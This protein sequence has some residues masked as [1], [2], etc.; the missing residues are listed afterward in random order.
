MFED[1][2]ELQDHE[3]LRKIG[4][5]FQQ[6]I[7]ILIIGGTIS[8]CVESLPQYDPSINPEYASMWLSIEAFCVICFSVDFGMRMGG[9]ITH[10]VFRTF[11]TDPMNWIDVA[12]IAPFY[13]EMLLKA[14]TPGGDPPPDLRFIRVI[15]L[16]RIF[17]MLRSPRFSSMAG[18]V[19]DI[20]ITAAPGLMIPLYFMMLAAVLLASLVYYA[21]KAYEKPYLVSADFMNSTFASGSNDVEGADGVARTTQ[22]GCKATPCDDA[23]ASMA[24]GSVHVC[25]QMVDSRMGDMV[26]KAV[27]WECAPKGIV[28]VLFQT[29]NGKWYDSDAFPSIPFTCWWC[30][31]TFTTVGYGDVMPRT[32]LGRILGVVTMQ[33]GIWFLAMPLAIVGDAFAQSWDKIKQKFER[34]NRKAAK[35][36][37]GGNPLKPI[38][39]EMKVAMMRMRAGVVSAQKSSPDAGDWPALLSVYEDFESEVVAAFASVDMSKPLYS[40]AKATDGVTNL[41]S[42]YGQST[43]PSG[44]PRKPVPITAAV[45]GS[46]DGASP[47]SVNLSADV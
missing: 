43:S 38:Q 31:V 29:P 34:D 7:N 23:V 16:A 37:K 13:L 36:A 27:F 35:L 25:Q 46:V 26:N 3:G 14:V 17:R 44:S 5:L 4:L 39:R 6:L 19:K 41:L 42:K 21:E 11:R 45:E 20:L 30:I 1:P 24:A 9:A 18:V 15:R 33:V 22:W 32:P 8:M 28:P 2:E 47:G 40:P 12:A 10:S